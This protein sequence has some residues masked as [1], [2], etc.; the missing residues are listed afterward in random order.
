MMKF[1]IVANWKCNPKTISQAEKILKEYK[2]VKGI[3]LIVCP[4]FP[5]I[6]QLKAKGAQDCF[7]QEGAF[8]GEISPAMLKSIGVCY[9][10]V[11]H[12]ERRNLFNETDEIVNKK[13][14]AVL[15]E[16]MTPIL[17]VGESAGERENNQTFEIIARQVEKGIEGI[18]KDKI[19]NI[20]LAY[21]PIWS[22]GTGN[23]APPEKIQE[24]RIFIKKKINKKYGDKASGSVR[25]IYGGS[26]DSKNVASY[27][28]DAGMD[29]VLVGNASLNVNEFNQMERRL[30]E[31][32]RGILR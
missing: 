18:A 32:P 17:C 4:P 15:Q 10:I 27:L 30:I 9:V 21:E 29:G 11:G 25:I 14:K 6:H 12:S 20:V 1:L 5:F 19:K 13:V 26:V 2:P 8:T 23:F 3:E 24:V 22:I 7:Y 16:N 31:P 28:F